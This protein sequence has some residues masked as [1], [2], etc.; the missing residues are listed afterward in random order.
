MGLEHVLKSEEQQCLEILS[1]WSPISFTPKPIC[2][3]TGFLGLR[4]S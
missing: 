2:S 4:G 3:P 1:D